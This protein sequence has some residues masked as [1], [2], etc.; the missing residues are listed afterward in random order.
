MPTKKVISKRFPLILGMILGLFVFIV[1]YTFSHEAYTHGPSSVGSSLGLAFLPIETLFF[2]IPSF[3]F[4]FSLG[5][6]ISW[7]F[8]RFAFN[9][10]VLLSCI[11]VLAF[12]FYLILPIF[13]LISAYQ[14]VSKIQTMN[15]QEL[16]EAV[17]YYQTQE[18]SAYTPFYFAAIVQNPQVDQLTLH[19][20]SQIKDKR[21]YQSMWSQWGLMGNNRKGRSVMRLI[22]SNPKT[23]PATLQ[24]LV[25]DQQEPFLLDEIARNPNTPTDILKGLYQKGEGFYGL[26]VNPQTPPELLKS[27]AAQQ[28]NT[29]ILGLISRNPNASEE[30]RNQ[31]QEKI[32][33]LEKRS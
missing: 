25:T 23:Q 20:I 14:T 5:Y 21:L 6:L 12:S 26:A 24:I 28:N 9:F 13:P 7:I 17:A 15:T 2:A 31:I 8:N 16:K 1:Y 10:K 32:R 30:L 4:G 27:L 11:V 18:G 29:T 33:T 3:I 19:Q 22:A